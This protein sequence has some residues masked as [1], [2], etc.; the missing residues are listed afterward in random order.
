MANNQEK[1]QEIGAEALKTTQELAAQAALRAQQM[2]RRASQGEAQKAP[3]VPARGGEVRKAPE[4]PPKRLSLKKTFTPQEIATGVEANSNSPYQAP[5]P[6]P[7]RNLPQNAPPV[8]QKPS[9]AVNSPLMTPK[10]K[11]KLPN[12]PLLN[13]RPSGSPQPPQRLIKPADP[14]PA[15]P[16]VPVRNQNISA[17]SS[18]QQQPPNISASPQ[19][20]QRSNM[21]STLS[22]LTN[23]PLPNQKSSSSKSSSKTTISPSEEL[24]SEDAL[25]GIESGLRNMERAMQ[26]QMNMRSMEAASQMQ[27]QFNPLE[28]KQNIRGMGSMD[29]LD[30]GPSN[31]RIMENLRL[32]FEASMGM[33]T[34]G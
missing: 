1:T 7:Q 9:S 10:F 23:S 17:A 4:V 8:P 21:S 22:S 6:I 20:S 31:L 11:D 34:M 19:L 5:V 33:R 32:K 14:L 25:R 26:E 29:R 16:Q 2:I 27:R 12:S 28:F 3:E 15:S 24:G 30:S 13:S 18:L